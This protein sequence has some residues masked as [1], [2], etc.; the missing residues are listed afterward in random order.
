MSDA[1]LGCH[2][3]LWKR[4]PPAMTP[5]RSHAYQ[6]NDWNPLVLTPTLVASVIMWSFASWGRVPLSPMALRYHTTEGVSDP[7]DT[8]PG[9]V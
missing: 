4:N 8:L 1:L 6:G 5:M 7:Y 9:R 3:Y 2:L